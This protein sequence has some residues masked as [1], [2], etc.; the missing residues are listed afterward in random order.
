[1]SQNENL[2]ENSNFD[3]V[4]CVCRV[5]IVQLPV[6]GGIFVLSFYFSFIAL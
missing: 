2:F 5:K 6:N 1:M 4:V 3:T